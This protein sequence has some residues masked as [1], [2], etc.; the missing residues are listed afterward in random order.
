VP[1]RNEFFGEI[2]PENRKAVLL[3]GWILE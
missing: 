2:S 3:E 1:V